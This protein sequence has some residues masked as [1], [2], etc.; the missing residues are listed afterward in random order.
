MGYSET[1]ILGFVEKIENLQVEEKETLK[2]A[3]LDID[4][5]NAELLELHRIANESNEKQEKKKRELRAISE[6]HKA[7]LRNLYVRG[8]SHL[9]MMIGAVAK[10]SIPAKNFRRIRSRLKRPRE[11]EIA[12]LQPAE[13]PATGPVQ[14]KP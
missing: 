6:T 11:D 2:K 8:S 1:Q 7:D 5:M 9:D 12:E 14:V 10:D 13:G 4:S 3:G